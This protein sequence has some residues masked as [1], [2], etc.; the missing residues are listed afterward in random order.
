MLTLDDVEIISED[1]PGWLVT[2]EGSLTVALDITVTE[3]IRYEGI[4][5]EFINRIQNYR[6]ESGLDV[7]DKIKIEIQKHAEIDQAIMVHR[8]YICT[9]TLG[10][11]ILLKEN[12]EEEG[13]KAVDIDE[14]INTR[15]KIKKLD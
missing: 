10:T 9:Q 1:I 15:L 7:T 6:K 12:V 5:R 3:E 14:N 13:S 8:E 11:E 4:A 2:N